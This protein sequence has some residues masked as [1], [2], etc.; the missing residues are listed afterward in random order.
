MNDEQW[1][2]SLR[3]WLASWG[4][5]P[6]WLSPSGLTVPITKDALSS[7]LDDVE[8]CRRALREIRTCALERAVGMPADSL[9]RASVSTIADEALEGQ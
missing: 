3:E 4:D 1:I 6:N 9:M 8:K 5:G 2:Q 7:L